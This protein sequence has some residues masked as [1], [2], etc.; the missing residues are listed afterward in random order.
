MQSSQFGAHAS[1]TQVPLAQWAWVTN[2]KVLQLTQLAPQC[3]AS[4]EVFAHTLPHRL[5]PL[6]HPLQV[7]LLHVAPLGHAVVHAPQWLG[8]FERFT[9]APAQLVCPDG[10]CDMHAPLAHTLPDGQIVPHAPQCC[11]SLARLTQAPPH[12]VSPA[13]HWLVH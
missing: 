10:H 1:I 5:V 11:G 8:S 3:A 9:Q 13:G 6:G 2:A 12:S 4:L 7:P